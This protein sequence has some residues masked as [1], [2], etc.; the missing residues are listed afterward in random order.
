MPL[1]VALGACAVAALGI[2]ILKVHPRH[3]AIVQIVRRPSPR[4]VFSTLPRQQLA[5]AFANLP[6]TFEPNVGQ[7][8]AKVKFVVRANDA[9]VLL[10]QHGIELS[11]AA[12]NA[13]SPPAT[14]RLQTRCDSNSSDRIMKFSHKDERCCAERR[15]TSWAAIRKNGLEMSRN[16]L[17]LNT[18]GLYPGIGARF[19]GGKSGLEYDSGCFTGQFT[20]KCTV[21]RRGR[22]CD[23]SRPQRQ[24]HFS[25]A[26]TTNRH[27]PP[28]NLSE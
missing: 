26:W 17:R 13:A 18:A 8:D 11:W 15:T 2:G 23:A 7:A 4:A 6:W 20:S 9:T 12:V 27:A 25:S 22:G 10:T 14:P 16:I 28:E 24:S 1:G 21:A 5:S 19:Y 3:A